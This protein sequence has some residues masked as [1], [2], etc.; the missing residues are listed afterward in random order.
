MTMPERPTSEEKVITT[1][2][3]SHCGG[4][5]LLKVHVRDGVITRIIFKPKKGKEGL[6]IQR[7]ETTPSI[8]LIRNG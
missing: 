2:C 5:C 7:V 6:A 3:R 4:G 8:S 1:A